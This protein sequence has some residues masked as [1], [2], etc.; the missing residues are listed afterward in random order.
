MLINSQAKEVLGYQ[1]P[2]SVYYG[3]NTDG[4]SAD[5]VREKARTSSERCARRTQMMYMKKNT[6]FIYNKG[7]K[8]LVRY[9][10]G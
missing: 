6:C 2:F 4:V 3:R 1:T 10:F 7:D 8:V 5:Q 9:P